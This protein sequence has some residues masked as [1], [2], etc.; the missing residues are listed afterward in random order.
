[1]KN[2]FK[3]CTLTA[4]F[5]LCAVWSHAQQP[6]HQYDPKRYRKD[7]V[8]IE[9][10][11]DPNANYYETLKAFREFWRGYQLPGEPEEMEG[12]DAFEREVGLE[13]GDKDRDKDKKEK[14]RK[15]KAPGGGDYSFEV[16][17]FKGW[18]QDAQPWVQPDGRILTQE[19]RQQMIDRQQ[20]ELKEIEKNQ[21]N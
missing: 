1:M 19:E 12:K 7:P 9:M 6:A 4:I 13:D 17:Q 11:N 14:K 20:Q 8:W 15:R 5:L 16:K 21:K 10:M 2:T 3:A 18:L